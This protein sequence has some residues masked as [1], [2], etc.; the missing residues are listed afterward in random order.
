MPHCDSAFLLIKAH[1]LLLMCGIMIF[2]SCT[3]INPSEEHIDSVELSMASQKVIYGE[4]TR[5]DVF[6]ANEAL[7]LRAKRSIFAMIPAPL[8]D[9]RNPNDVRLLSNTLANDYGLCADQR[10]LD[11][12]T[13]ASCSSTLIDDDLLVTA[14][15]CIRSQQSCL[16]QRF[17]LGYYMEADG[18]A[19]LTTEHIFS[20]LQLVA[21]YDD[22][23]VDYAFVK[24]NRPVPI[25]LGE[26]APVRLSSLPLQVGDPLVMMGFPSGLPLKID[27]GGFVSDPRESTNDFFMATVDA[28][29]GNSG[30]GVFNELGEQVGILVR[31]EQD[32]I[33]RGQCS[34]VN[35]LSIDRGP[36]DDAENITYLHQGLSELCISGYQSERLCGGNPNS[37]GLCSTC[38]PDRPCNDGLTCG[39]FSSVMTNLTFCS[40]TCGMNDLCPNGHSCIAGQCEPNFSRVCNTELNRVEGID[41]CGRPLGVIEDCGEEFYCRRGACLL[42]GDGDLCSNPTLI[43]PVTQVLRGSLVEGYENNQIGSC[44][45]NGPERFYSFTLDQGNH[46]TALAEGFDTVLY[47][48]EGEACFPLNELMCDDD[49]HPNE[50]LG[51]LLD[52]DLNP[53]SYTLAL[54]SF[55]DDDLGDFTLSLQF[56][57]AACTLG[58]ARCEPGGQVSICEQSIEANC[59]TWSRPLNCPN[60]LTC[61]L[62]QCLTPLPGDTCSVQIPLVSPYPERIQGEFTDQHSISHQP[63]CADQ[64]IADINYQL[65]LP[66]DARVIVSYVAGPL[67]ALSLRSACGNLGSELNCAPQVIGGAPLQSN[68]TAGQYTL[69]LSALALGPYQIDLRVEPLCMDECSEGAQRCTQDGTGLEQCSMGTEGCTVWNFDRMCTGVGGCVG[70]LC[71]DECFHE[72]AQEDLME[73]LNLS[74]RRICRVTEF[75]CR[76]W[77]VL[78]PCTQDERCIGDGTCLS[79][80]VDLGIAGMEGGSGEPVAGMIAGTTEAGVALGGEPIPEG[81]TLSPEPNLWI[82]QIRP[83]EIEIPSRSR[84][85]CDQMP[86]SNLPLVSLVLIALLWNYRRRLA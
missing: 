66:F 15:H 78:D 3:E 65:Q 77:Q 26:P 73:C 5:V 43:E 47:L 24:L 86:S 7:A 45:G 71:I 35:Q 25:E 36:G 21:T 75:G 53:G 52:L 74:E 59:P 37:G 31:G 46:L 32:Y 28:F 80:N 39:S 82:G 62:G 6:E 57:D 49:S 2:G 84:G 22:G 38:D 13:A 68:L 76:V 42:R 54:D 67:S 14:G 79:E 60:G 16:N 34:V 51:S 18:L 29:G 70:D 64:L 72:C 11:Q 12:P 17:V 81:G 55:I 44:A 69:T 1:V 85:G 9:T 48:Y 20:C 19:T 63:F 56:C 27:D 61:V 40:P 83:R 23:D 41:I 50:R 30:S 33:Q 4:D 58:E 8:I 10:Y